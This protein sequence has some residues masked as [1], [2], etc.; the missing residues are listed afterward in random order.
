MGACRHWCNYRKVLKE[1]SN[2]LT[3]RDSKWVVCVIDCIVFCYTLLYSG[4]VAT[5]PGHGVQAYRI[6]EAS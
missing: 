1:K 2:Y 3:L 6:S 5:V 4:L